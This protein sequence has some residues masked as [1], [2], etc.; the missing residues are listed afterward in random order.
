MGVGKSS[1]ICCQTWHGGL[2]NTSK[3]LPLM[4]VTTFWIASLSLILMFLSSIV[5]MQS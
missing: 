5:E 2:K 1:D 4:F 3:P